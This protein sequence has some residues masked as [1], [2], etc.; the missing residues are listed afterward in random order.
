MNTT[1]T[2]ERTLV[3]KHN[4]D[5]LGTCKWQDAASFVVSG[6][7]ELIAD[8]PNHRVHP[9]MFRPVAIRLVKAIRNLWRVEVPWGKH[10]V[11]V[12]DN[13]TCQYCGKKLAR[14]KATIDH[15]IPKD[16]GGKNGW[17]NTVTACFPC[18]NTKNNRTPSQAR[19]HLKRQPY[20][21]TI[22]EFINK[23]IKVDGLDKLV[24][25]LGIY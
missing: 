21:P 19:M 8:D 23:Q 20:Q 17:K 24:R 15:V 4:F 10:A 5:V 16:H 18:N 13:F 11:H 7:A 1:A 12:R 3:L 9:K 25:D 22:M 14:A 2:A 6:K